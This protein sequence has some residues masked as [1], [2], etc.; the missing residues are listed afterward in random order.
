[1]A[2]GPTIDAYNRLADQWVAAR[3]VQDVDHVR[4][5]DDGRDGLPMLDIGCGPGWQLTDVAAPAIG[6]DASSAMLDLVPGH[7]PHA[8]RILGE[9]EALPLRRGSIGG[10]VS[11]RVHVHVPATQLPMALA[12]LH[13]ALAPG[14]RA[15]LHMVDDRAGTEVRSN[16]MFAGRL[17]AGWSAEHLRRV[18]IGAGFTVEALTPRPPVEADSLGALLVRLVRVHTLSDTVGP[19]MNLLICGLNPSPSSAE[20]GIGFFRAGNRFWPAALAAGIV[21]RDRDPRHALKHHGIGMTDLVKRATRTAS[22]LNGSEYR[23]GVTRVEQM[24]RWL[25][26]KAVCFVGLA[27]WRA[28]VDRTAAAG[29]QPAGLGETPVYLMPSTSGLNAHARL[30]DLTEHLT[31]AIRLSDGRKP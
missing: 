1:M 8:T 20:T 4:W 15:F 2:D 22:E 14:S 6:L 7:A 19:N 3:T 12:D 23:D 13:H 17:F 25:K 21:S 30:A 18:C 29:V 28:A 24:I 31:S 10:A 5:V 16:R 26:P 27:G 9:A 11:N